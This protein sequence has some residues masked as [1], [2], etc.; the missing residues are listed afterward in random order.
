MQLPW[1][2]QIIVQLP[3]LR[4]AASIAKTTVAATTALFCWCEPPALHR[5]VAAAAAA[6]W[7]PPLW[8]QLLSFA[9][10]SHLLGTA[11]LLVCTDLSQK[12]P[13]WTRRELQRQCVLLQGLYR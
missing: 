2:L 11:G 1:L 5:W 9:G 8:L 7:K 3:P 6:E 12:Y 13:P 4:A 10:A